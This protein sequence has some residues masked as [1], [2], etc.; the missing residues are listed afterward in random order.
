[1]HRSRSLGVA[2]IKDMPLI[3]DL[4]TCYLRFIGYH[5]P[6][7]ISHRISGLETNISPRRKPRADIGRGPDIRC[8]INFGML[9]SIYH[10]IQ[11]M[12]FNKPFEI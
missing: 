11:L 2:T 4:Q 7:L 5:M 9:Y 12:N 1:M 10:M 8:D 3:S 6:K